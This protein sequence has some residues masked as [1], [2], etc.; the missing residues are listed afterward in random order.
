MDSFIHYTSIT[1]THGGITTSYIKFLVLSDVL[2]AKII[3]QYIS[4]HLTNH[5]SKSMYITSQ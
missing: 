4:I 5:S 3:V 2:S 1:Y